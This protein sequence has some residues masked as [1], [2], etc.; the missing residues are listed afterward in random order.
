MDILV[1]LMN[2]L[3]GILVVQGLFSIVTGVQKYFAGQKN[4]NAQQMDQGINSMIS[5]GAL[6]TITGG[7]IA[8]INVALGQIKF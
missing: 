7:I 2:V 6:A 8:A 1:K 3:G 4:D 5:G